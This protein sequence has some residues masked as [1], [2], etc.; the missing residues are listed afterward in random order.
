[1]SKYSIIRQKAYALLKSKTGELITEPDELSIHLEVPFPDF[2]KY[3][4]NKRIANL[5]HDNKS[6]IKAD[7]RKRWFYSNKAKLQENL[8]KLMASQ[9]E[10]QR[11]K[12]DGQ[13]LEES[14]SDPLLSAIDPQRVWNEFS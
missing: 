6:A 7:L 12:G 8:Y 3:V 13:I 9:D 10:L 14:G 5:L 1:M 2:I 4:Y 11:L